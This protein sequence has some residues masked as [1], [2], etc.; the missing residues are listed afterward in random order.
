MR[1]QIPHVSPL[2]FMPIF[3]EKLEISALFIYF[4]FNSKCKNTNENALIKQKKQRLSHECHT[5]IQQ[6]LLKLKDGLKPS[7]KS[8]IY[9]F[10]KEFLY[11]NH[12]F[13]KA[14]TT[15]TFDL[16]QLR[17]KSRKIY[18]FALFSEQLIPV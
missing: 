18:C 8:W 3:R 6:I 9:L 16:A 7:H 12:Y 1:F 14:L 15:N 10:F 2:L 4:S 13:L 17:L 11:N 5:D